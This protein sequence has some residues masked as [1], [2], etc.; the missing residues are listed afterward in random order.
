MSTLTVSVSIGR[1]IGTEPMPLHV[2]EEFTDRL[3]RTIQL[4][5][6]SVILAQTL[7]KGQW[8]DANGKTVHEDAAIVLA[9][10]PACYSEQLK[11]V[12]ANLA[13]V[14]AQDGIGYTACE[15]AQSYVPAETPARTAASA[16]A[17]D[18]IL[19]ENR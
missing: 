17:L 10:V 4:V 14:Y 3:Y 11:L 13:Y 19:Q 18:A 9:Q 15:S 5:P 2:W 6:C 12:L 8:T 1:N 16:H 7:G